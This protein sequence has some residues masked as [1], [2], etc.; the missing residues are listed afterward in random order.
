MHGKL[1]R[2]WI[3]YLKN[4]KLYTKF[5]IHYREAN[6]SV[7]TWGIANLTAKLLNGDDYIMPNKTDSLEFDSFLSSLRAMDRFNPIHSEC[8][9]TSLA[10]KFGELKGYLQKSDKSNYW[11][12]SY[13]DPKQT[14]ATVY[15]PRPNPNH[16]HIREREERSKW[17]DRFYIDTVKNRYRR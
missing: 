2:E 1:F 4:R 12:L 8:H 5:I 16:R 13:S 10:T 15:S 11:S 6:A 7:R 3:F 9:W 17:Y 14:S